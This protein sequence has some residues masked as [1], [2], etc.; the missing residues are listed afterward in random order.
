M[1]DS[2]IILYV[3]AEFSVLLL[4]ICA[5]L[6][7][8]AKSLKA[9]IRRLEDKVVNLRTGMAEAKKE[10][11]QALQQLTELQGV[12]P[13][14]YLDFLDDEIDNTRQYHQTLNPDRDIVLDIALDT[15]IERQI[16]SLRHAFFI[17]E[18]EAR[19]A[20]ENN[21]SNWGVLESKLHQLIQFYETAQPAPATEPEEI[22]LSGPAEAADSGEGGTPAPAHAGDAVQDS[23]D[24]EEQLQHYETVVRDLTNESRIMLNT[25]SSLEQDNESLRQQ[26]EAVQVEDGQASILEKLGATQQ[27]LLNLQTR[28]IELEERYMELKPQ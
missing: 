14:T 7:I 4:V 26:L 28:H 19:Y 12:E 1:P 20:G 6:F 27:E 21:C 24:Q 17:A 16:A 8:H 23:S 2:N 22:A 18:K 25:I 3:V 5:F 9:L 11:Q 15:P 13:K 10:T